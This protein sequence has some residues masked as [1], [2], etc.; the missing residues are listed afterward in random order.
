MLH[1]N[2]A[3]SKHMIY[4]GRNYVVRHKDVFVNEEKVECAV[5]FDHL[6]HRLSTVD[7]SSM[8]TAAV[9]RF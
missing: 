5:T 1:F 3:K 9:P 4:T 7:K 6:G 8:I 2:S